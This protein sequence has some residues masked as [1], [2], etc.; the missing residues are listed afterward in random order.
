M[1]AVLPVHAYAWTEND[2][3]GSIGSAA[4]SN[5]DHGSLT[6]DSG[7]G[8]ALADAAAFACG[9]ELALVNGGDLAGNLHAGELT[10]GEVCFALAADRP[11]AVCELTPVQL[12]A[13]LEL[14]LSH[15]TVDPTTL[16]I[17]RETSAFAGFPQIAGFT[18]RYDASATVG[19]RVVSIK[20][21]DGELNLSDDNTH[22][23]LACTEHLL[24]GGYGELGFLP[25]YTLAGQTESEAL[26]LYIREG[27]MNADYTDS[28]RVTVIGVTDNTII[29]RL[30]IRGL[31]LPVC[32]LVVV[33]FSV[34]HRRRAQETVNTA[35]IDRDLDS[36][37]Q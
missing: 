2:I 31:V 26:A 9:A 32:L 1:M 24:Q 7:L 37:F 12:R 13:L 27:G 19:Q 23:T 25:S 6:D 15:I 33:L 21:E 34:R 20:T 11:L 18:V 4:F 3:V 36:F 5:K 29:D 8:A 14:C 16:S 28:D 10:Y 35:A 17:D 30:G 22:L